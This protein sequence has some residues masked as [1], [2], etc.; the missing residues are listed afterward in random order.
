MKT[1]AL[2]L[3][4]VAL[5]ACATPGPPAM[6][7]PDSLAAAETAFAAHSVRENMRPAFLANFADDG[8]FVRGGWT[9]S[10]AYLAT[11]PN[12]PIVLDWKPVYVEVA[13]SGEL[14]LSTGPT[15]IT[16]TANPSAAPSYGQ[17]VS[18]WRR[19]GQGPWKVEVDL[20][21]NHAQPALWDQSVTAVTSGSA[22]GSMLNARTLRGAEENFSRAS[23]ASGARSAYAE[24]ASELLRFYRAGGSPALGKA[25][26]LASPGMTQDRIVWTVDR[27]EAAHS[28]DLGYA[29]GSYASADAPAKVLGHYLRVWRNEGGTWRVALDVTNVLPPAVQ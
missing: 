11:R 27:V 20:G 24:N 10:N 26:A 14:G 12:P 4:A 15:K 22:R 2:A 8:V 6:N 17:Y 23:A 28:G 18:V 1:P 25:G 16:S 7:A 21:I 5:A 3:A 13:A 9:V 19:Q 29:R